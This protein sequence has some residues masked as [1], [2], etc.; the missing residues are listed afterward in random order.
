MKKRGFALIEIV[1]AI[2]V[3]SFTVLY[4]FQLFTTGFVA[5]KKSKVKT[6]AT[7]FAQTQL[8]LLAA[9]ATPVPPASGTLTADNFQ[10][11]YNYTRTPYGGDP[12]LGLDQVT[13]NITGPYDGGQ[14][15]KNFQNLTLITYLPMPSSLVRFLDGGTSISP[16]GP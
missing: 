16:G 11:H 15:A 2:L 1:V 4:T 9:R 6:L 14:P 7:K 10:F 12:S 5:Y 3:L 8:E 13:L